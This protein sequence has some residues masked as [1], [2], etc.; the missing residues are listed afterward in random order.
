[1]LRISSSARLITTQQAAELLQVTPHTITNWIKDDLVP[2]VEL[3]S[4]GGK[5]TYRLPLNALL[6]TLSGNYDLLPAIKVVDEHTSEVDP[7]D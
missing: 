3:P 7:Q 1:M 2:Y 4:N 5:K 6:Q